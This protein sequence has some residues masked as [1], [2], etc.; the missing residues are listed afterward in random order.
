MVSDREQARYVLT[1]PH[2]KETSQHRSTIEGRIRKASIVVKANCRDRPL[3]QPEDFRLRNQLS[4]YQSTV[5][6]RCSKDARL[7]AS[8]RTTI[9][10]KPWLGLPPSCS[11][12]PLTIEMRMFTVLR[13]GTLFHIT[14][15]NNHRENFSR[16]G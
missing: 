8:G 9:D 2:R 5:P 4:R 3:M 16:C 10:S 6:E 13:E 12:E 7:A 1:P 11:Y 14:V 15:T